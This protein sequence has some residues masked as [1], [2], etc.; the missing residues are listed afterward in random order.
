MRAVF[1]AGSSI[2]T[3]WRVVTA[4]RSCFIVAS[5]LYHR[6]LHLVCRETLERDS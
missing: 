4:I 3:K 6:V 1:G 2:L 5:C